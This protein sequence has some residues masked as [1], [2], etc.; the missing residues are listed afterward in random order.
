MFSITGGPPIISS[1][2][3]QHALHGQKGQIKCFI[4]STPPPDRIAWSWKENVLESG[5]SGRYT[6]ETVST[7]EGVIS[8][9]TISNIVRADF[10]TI[11]NCTAWNSFGSDTEIIRLKEQAGG[12][13]LVLHPLLPVPQYEVMSLPRAAGSFIALEKQEWLPADPTAPR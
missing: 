3:T 9:L 1:T 11:Y 10:Q 7:D 12:H 13:G 4:R 2:Q 5:T 6:V 8:T